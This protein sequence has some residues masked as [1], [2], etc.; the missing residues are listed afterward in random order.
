MFIGMQNI[1]FEYL[2]KH[3]QEYGCWLAETVV[4]LNF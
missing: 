1:Y 4:K 2:V 3:F